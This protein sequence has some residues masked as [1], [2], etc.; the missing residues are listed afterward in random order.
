MRIRTRPSTVA[1]AVLVGLG[2]TACSSD[3]DGGEATQSTAVDTATVQVDD[4][5]FDPDEI[6]V[7]VGATVTW[8]WVGSEPHNV[9]G[10]GFESDIQQQ[11]TFEQ[12]F[13]EAGSYDY[14]C[15]VHP[16]MEGT[17]EVSN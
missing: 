5:F 3:G 6:D 8:E 14:V 11:G 7:G 10:D 9:V 1:L 16:G 17:V 12:T 2:A 13:E 4:N 15:T